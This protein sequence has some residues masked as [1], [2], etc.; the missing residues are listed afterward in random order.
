MH[1]KQAALAVVVFMA[2][3]ICGGYLFSKSEPRSILEVT[4]C[5]NRCYKPNEVAGLIM[6][7]AILRGPFVFPN[8]V[9]ESDTCLAI[10]HPRPWDRV[11][12]VL[13]PK[14]DIRNITTLTLADTPYVMGCFAMIRD[15]VLQDKL[16]KYRVY[17]NGPGY[18]DVAYLHFHLIAR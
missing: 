1:F 7:A 12:Y 11:H 2:G 4:N 9:R 15:L 5:K 16:E 14:Q 13:F 17:T 10:R 6:S 18:Q 3:L 8:V